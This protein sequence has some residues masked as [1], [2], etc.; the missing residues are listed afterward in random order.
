MGFNICEYGSVR[1]VA[2][3]FFDADSSRPDPI[4]P[5]QVS[6]TVRAPDGTETT[7]VYD[8]DEEV[9]RDSIGSY[10]AWVACDQLGVWYYRWFSDGDG[11]AAAERRF[12]VRPA[13]AI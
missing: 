2:A 4:D 3:S 10:Y 5:D 7:Y 11:E 13:Y 6:L 1:K 9:K 8:T 12:D